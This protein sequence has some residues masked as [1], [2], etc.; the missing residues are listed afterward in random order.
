M[1]KPIL[2]LLGFI[3]SLWEAWWKNKFLPVIFWSKS[4]E[5]S[6]TYVFFVYPGGHLCI[7]PVQCDDNL[8][9][10]GLRVISQCCSQPPWHHRVRWTKKFI[11]LEWPSIHKEWEMVGKS[12]NL[13][14]SLWYNHKAHSSLS[15]GPQWDCVPIA[16]RGN[17]LIN[18]PWLLLP[19]CLTSHSLRC[20]L[21]SHTKQC[22]KLCLSIF[23]LSLFSFGKSKQNQNEH[24]FKK[25]YVLK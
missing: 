9:L 10:D 8:S 16:H 7:T 3:S 22:L 14:S 18:T 24:T 11:S 20:F 19:L 12:A 15:E 6:P 23:F 13:M 17:L 2:N 4:L 21:R 1:T 5:N 25:L